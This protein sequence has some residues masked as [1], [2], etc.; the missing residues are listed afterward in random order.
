MGLQ[1]GQTLVEL[2]CGRVFLGPTTII[3]AI[4][5]KQSKREG[6]IVSRQGK[7][8]ISKCEFTPSIEDGI[9]SITALALSKRRSNA[10]R[11]TPSSNSKGPVP[12]AYHRKG[13]CGQ[14]IY[15][16]KNL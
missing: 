8:C 5:R 3:T 10:H 7:L 14:D 12:S 2:S 16:A 1:V 11:T 13:K 4:V 9:K 15:L 6:I